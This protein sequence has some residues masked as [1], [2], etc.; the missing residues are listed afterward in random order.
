MQLRDHEVGVTEAADDVPDFPDHACAGT[1]HHVDLGSLQ[2]FSGDF[3]TMKDRK[4]VYEA[5]Q[6]WHFPNRLSRA[7]NMAPNGAVSEYAPLHSGSLPG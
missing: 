7:L 6:L 5:L 4:C 3:F 1:S 2:D